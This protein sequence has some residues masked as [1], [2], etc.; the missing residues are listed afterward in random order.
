MEI[1]GYEDVK[2][3][4]GIVPVNGESVEEGTGSVDGDGIQF[5][6]GLDE[7]VGVSLADVLD[8]KVIN[9]KGKNYGL[10]GVLP[11]RRGSGNRGEAKVGKVSF[12]TVVGNAAGLFKA[13]HAFSDI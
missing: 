8:P 4:C 10:G 9:N 3:A 7:V 2:G 6:E 1:F 13:G 5:S 11:E 12:E